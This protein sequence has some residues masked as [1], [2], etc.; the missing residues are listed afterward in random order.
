MYRIHTEYM[1]GISGH[2]R[3]CTSINAAVYTLRPVTEYTYSGILLALQL[4]DLSITDD[5]TDYS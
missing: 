1:A 5:T 3:R 2:F 4:H